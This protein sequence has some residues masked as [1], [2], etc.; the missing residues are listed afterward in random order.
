MATAREKALHFVEHEQAFHLGTLLTESP[1]P[2]TARFSQTIA[3]NIESGVRL[4]AA[5]DADIVPVAERVLASETVQRLVETFCRVFRAGGRVFFTGCG[6]TGRLSLLLEAAWRRILRQAGRSGPD[7]AARFPDLADRVVGVMAGGDFALIRAVEGFEDFTDFGRYQLA[8]LGVAPGDAVVA[9]TEGGETSFVIGTAWEG[10]DRGASVFFVYNNP[11]DALRRCVERSREVIDEPRITKLDLSTGPMAVAGST[12]MQATTV[13]LLVVGAALEAAL[14]EVLAERLSGEEVARLGIRPGGPADCAAP[15]AELLGELAS[16]SAV[17]ALASAVELEESVYRNGG[18]VTYL[19]DSFLLDVLTDTTERS[20]TFRLPPFRQVGDTVSARSW[21]FVKN[22][23][24]PTRAAWHNALGRLPRGLDWDTNVYRRLGAPAALVRH[25]PALGCEDIYR[26]AIGRE[27]DPSRWQA[28]DSALV[29]IL[30]GREIARAADESPGFAAAAGAMA[31]DY[32][33]RAAVTIGPHPMEAP[34]IETSIHVACR[35]GPSPLALWEHL[36]VKLALNTISTATM[37][38]MG[39]VLGNW[40]HWV[41]PSNKKLLDRGTR[42]I[43]E[44]TGL[45]Y[46]EACVA[47][48]ETIEELEPQVQRTNDAPSPVALA[49]ERIGLDER[50]RD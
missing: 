37:A 26:F 36:A 39:R 7:L 29:C 48:F 22:P 17:S 1:H 28:D 5:V 41:A 49:V 32:H 19:A 9:I 31:D 42:L 44:L 14:V 3:G 45:P 27:L 40:M 8:E 38:R 4:L 21:A 24:L 16:P 20:P 2:K 47:L 46:A 30:V 23:L 25:P 6:S 15:F 34:W 11:T 13:E 35:P 18:L 10:L 50:Y 33:R 43:A 12:R